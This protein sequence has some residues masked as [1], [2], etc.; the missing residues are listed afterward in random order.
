MYNRFVLGQCLN[1]N[2]IKFV[3]HVRYPHLLLLLKLH[4]IAWNLENKLFWCLTTLPKMGITK[5]IP[6]KT[7][8]IKKEPRLH[9]QMH[10]NQRFIGQAQDPTTIVNSKPSCFPVFLTLC[11]FD[12]VS[13]KI[14]LQ[15]DF[16][17]FLSVLEAFIKIIYKLESIT[18]PNVA[19]VLAVSAVFT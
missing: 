18:K 8:N 10:V 15:N 6:D 9:S 2:F 3:P 5:L 14:P 13:N 17:F 11:Y 4:I 12:R 16:I 1:I 7:F 19:T